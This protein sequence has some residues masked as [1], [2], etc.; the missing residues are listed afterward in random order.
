MNLITIVIP[1]FNEENNIEKCILNLKKQTNHS[2]NVI[3]ID[4]GST[5]KTV[6]ILK[7]I[8]DTEVK[9]EYTILRQTNKG[10]A[11]ARKTGIKNSSTEYIMIY[12]CDDSISDDYIECFYTTYL[13]HRDADII[14]PNALIQTEDKSWYEFKFYSDNTILKP[15]ECLKNS[16]NGWK[17]HGWFCA[18]KDIF[19]NS[20]EDYKKFNP[21]AENF[22][23][24][25][26]VITRL[27]FHNSNLVVK[28]S[29]IYY[30]CFNQQSTTKKIN[31]MSYLQ[32]NNAL[33]IDELFSNLPDLYYE[34]K[35]E[36]LNTIWG[37][38]RFKQIHKNKLK[39]LDDWETLLKYSVNKLDYFKLLKI[40][41][42]KEKIKLSILKAKYF[43]FN[44]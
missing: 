13:T 2:F 36:L 14:L 31:Q 20:Y 21:K 30:Y 37:R 25:D 39:N 34:T 4:D 27:N 22:I 29:A 16:I 15:M 11:E 26:E 23:N 19:L 28:S 40:L 7:N 42:I 9:F 12:D 18:R 10:A 24:N 3:F 43:S 6:D 17:I 5:D 41:P 38:F 35:L 32:I 8:L 1:M 44:K 33:I